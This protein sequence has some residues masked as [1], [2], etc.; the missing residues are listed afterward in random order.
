MTDRPIGYLDLTM[1]VYREDDQYVSE[2]IELGVASCGDSVDEAFDAVSEAVTLYLEVIT[3]DGE[4]ERIL[5]ERGLELHQGEPPED[6]PE[7]PVRARPREF[8]SPRQ[9]RIPA[10]A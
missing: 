10:L 7:V 9:V 8:V 1:K 6:G 5:R 2:C 3:E 4:L